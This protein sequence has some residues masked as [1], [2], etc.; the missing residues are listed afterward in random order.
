MSLTTRAAIEDLYKVEGKAE[1]VN[2][3]IVEMPPAGEDPNF[4][5]GEIFA[6]LR[7][8][9]RRTGHGRA[10]TD[11]AGF[12]V[13]L[14]HRESF[15]PDAAYHVGPR[16]GMRFAAGAPVFAVE[17]RSEHDYGP[18]AERALAAKRADYFACGTQVVWD[19]DLLSAD[20][21]KAYQASDPEH[22]VIYRCGEIAA[23][24]PA[25]PGWRMAVD[26]LF[27]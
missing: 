23:A 14:P 6:Q 13:S 24:E 20:V 15:S 4:A 12:H 8:Y 5:G 26:E 21:I 1:L 16:T 11:G 17:M 9:V 10:F 27:G 7:E 19:V 22:P 25:V 3:E 2:G 18:A